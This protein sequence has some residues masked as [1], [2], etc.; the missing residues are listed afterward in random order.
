MEGTP[1]TVAVI[2]AVFPFSLLV[3]LVIG[4]LLINRYLRVG[5]SK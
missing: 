2:F 1:A 3:V 5:N 4:N